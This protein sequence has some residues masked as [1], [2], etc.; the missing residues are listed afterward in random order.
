[1]CRFV[2]RGAWSKSI[3][4]KSKHRKK[5]RKG[6]KKSK[7]CRPLQYLAST[8][9]AWTSFG[10]RFAAFRPKHQFSAPQRAARWQRTSNAIAAFPQAGALDTVLGV[11]VRRT[12][13]GLRTHLDGI[14]AT[15]T[16]DHRQ[17]SGALS[18]FM[19]NAFTIY[20]FKTS[21]FV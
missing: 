6:K 4:I 14:G 8:E 15:S 11:S 13:D 16:K 10:P 12:R 3:K 17:I 2:A 7:L 18:I 20:A 9:T 5:A 21:A 19:Y 1:V